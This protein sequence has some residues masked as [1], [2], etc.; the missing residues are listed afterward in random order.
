[1]PLHPIHPVLRPEK[2]GPSF[3]AFIPLQNPTTVGGNRK[4][5]LSP[6]HFLSLPLSLSLASAPHQKLL[7]GLNPSPSPPSPFL[8]LFWYA[9]EQHDTYPY[10]TKP[11]TGQYE[12]PVLVRQTFNI[13]PTQNAHACT[14]RIKFS[15]VP[16]YTHGGAMPIGHQ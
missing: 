9:L 15:C 11:V 1:M 13:V 3:P 5:S 10:H 14:S 6:S 16:S 12:P 4:V 8:S 7:E 2:Q